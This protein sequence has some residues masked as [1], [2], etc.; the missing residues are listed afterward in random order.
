MISER[1]VALPPLRQR[2]IKV[3]QGCGRPVWVD[4]P[5][6]HIDHHVRATSCRAPGDEQALLDMALSVIMTP[7]RKTLRCGRLF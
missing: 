6:F 3:P 2:L 5:D 1:I 7:L 4:D